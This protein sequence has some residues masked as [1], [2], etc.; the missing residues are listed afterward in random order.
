MITRR[1]FLTR[2]A[3]VATGASI[4]V[5][6]GL[7][8]HAAAKAKPEPETDADYQVTC[9]ECHTPGLRAVYLG[10]KMVW[11]APLRQFSWST[12]DVSM[13]PELGEELMVEWTVLQKKEEFRARVI[14]IVEIR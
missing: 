5:G 14:S 7:L 13:V 2:A 1:S 9:Q 11:E 3:V 8:R 6:T 10:E 4:G 12:R